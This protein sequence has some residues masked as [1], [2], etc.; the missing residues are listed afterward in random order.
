MATTIGLDVHKDTI[1][2][3]AIDG[4]GA[5]IHQGEFDNTVEGIADLV[6]WANDHT[7]L[8]RVGLEEE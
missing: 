4:S 2:G 3:A 7:Q 8:S 1:T 5:I 6:S